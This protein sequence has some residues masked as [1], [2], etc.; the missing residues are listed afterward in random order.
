MSG[1]GWWYDAILGGV[2]GALTASFLCVCSERLP[3]GESIGGRS[4][5]ACGRQL[6]WRENIPIFGWLLCKGTARCCRAKIPPRYVWAE[7]F[8]AIAWAGAGLLSGT[9]PTG[10]LL[11][12]AGSAAAVL[13][14][15]WQRPTAKDEE[16][17]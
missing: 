5:C 13:G 7:T 10:A 6:R 9:V 17:S 1:I 14:T 15:T 11:L 4:M 3:K 16:Q 2:L 8:L 12:A